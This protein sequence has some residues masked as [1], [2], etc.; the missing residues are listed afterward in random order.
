[1]DKHDYMKHEPDLKDLVNLNILNYSN[2]TTS[3]Q[4]KQPSKQDK[5]K[6]IQEYREL[7][8][9]ISTMNTRLTMINRDIKS[10]LQF[11]SSV[12]YNQYSDNNTCILCMNKHDNY[13]EYNH[14]LLYGV[15]LYHIHNN[16]PFYTTIVKSDKYNVDIDSNKGLIVMDN[17]NSKYMIK[18]IDLNNLDLID[19][20]LSHFYTILEKS[21]SFIVPILSKYTD[22][23]IKRG[24]INT[25]VDLF[26]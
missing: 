5:T 1:M 21:M 15:N 19:F 24:E 3:K 12:F 4:S 11:L 23:I 13:K 18:D 6:I 14:V 8:N 20:I 16:N 9:T 10:K 26:K 17:Y 25:K 22:L 7:Y 2:N